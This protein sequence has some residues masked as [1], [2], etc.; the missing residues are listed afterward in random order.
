[1]R[2]IALEGDLARARDLG[3]DDLCRRLLFGGDVESVVMRFPEGAQRYRIEKR[4]RCPEIPSAA[5]D[6]NTRLRALAGECIIAESVTAAEGVD[7]AV[8][9]TAVHQAAED[10]AAAISQT[11]AGADPWILQRA[12]GRRSE[13][14]RA[15]ELG[16]ESRYKL[17]VL[18]TLTRIQVREHTAQGWT[19]SEQRTRVKGAYA[20]VPFFIG[21][22]GEQSMYVAPAIARQQAPSIS[23]EDL[24]RE[25]YGWRIAEVAPP[26]G[27][28]LQTTNMSGAL[29]PNFADREALE[30]ILGQPDGTPLTDSESQVVSASVAQIIRQDTY[31]ADDIETLRAVVRS[32]NFIG[33][34][35]LHVARPERALELVSLLPD[36][37]SRLEAP[38]QHDIE[39]Q[40]YDFAQ[41]AAKMPRPA[42]RPFGNRIRALLLDEE[43]GKYAGSLLEILPEIADDPEPALRFWIARP[44]VNSGFLYDDAIVGLCRVAHPGRDDIA[45]IMQD[46]LRKYSGGRSM[47]QDAYHAAVAALVQS[48]G[49]QDAEAL[50]ARIA[51]PRHRRL[52]QTELHAALQTPWPDNCA[53][54]R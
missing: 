24:L 49:R 1:M 33:Y 7:A 2:S 10:E 5:P 22:Y 37:V 9:Q 15:H 4:V 47:A 16:R 20:V 51:E 23:V 54:T 45:A 50:G 39:N 27:A 52:Y 6:R 29:D 8:T 28:P 41:F 43:R 19:N 30:R 53:R 31:S 25:R 26:D 12:Y 36:I 46:F 13:T 17:W 48:A 35:D 42:L 38:P 3:C 32:G 40:R 11:G 44:E 18:D 34:T 14:V 21:V